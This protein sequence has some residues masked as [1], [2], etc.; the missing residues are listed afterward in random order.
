MVIVLVSLCLY[1]S[2]SYHNSEPC[3]EHNSQPNQ[4]SRAEHHTQLIAKEFLVSIL[5][6][7]WNWGQEM[8][9]QT[10][11][12][13]RGCLISPAF[14]SLTRHPRNWPVPLQRTLLATPSLYLSNSFSYIAKRE[15]PSSV[16]WCLVQEILR[17]GLGEQALGLHRI[18]FTPVVPSG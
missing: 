14:F 9:T 2:H 10:A 6:L 12:R 18:M 13:S 1:K 16:S 8:R 11:P 3:I 15:A 4:A 7:S 17:K 5:G